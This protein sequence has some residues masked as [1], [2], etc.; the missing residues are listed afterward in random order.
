MRKVKVL[1][2]R[3]TAYFD[4][5]DGDHGFSGFLRH[6]VKCIQE[7]IPPVV[8]YTPNAHQE[9]LRSRNINYFI[10]S[11]QELTF[12]PYQRRQNAQLDD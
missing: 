7:Y 2:A 12:P 1:V 4:G 3:D 8:R 11:I 9:G 10:C 5:N 6:V